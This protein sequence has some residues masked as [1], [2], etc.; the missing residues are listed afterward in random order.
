MGNPR[1]MSCATP[2]SADTG[3]IIPENWVAG[4]TVRITVPNMAAICVLANAE[5]SIP[6]DVVVVT[7]SSAP[8][9]SVGKEPSSGT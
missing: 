8:T 5:I 4:S 7:Y 1:P 9:R 2:D 3:T 6:Q